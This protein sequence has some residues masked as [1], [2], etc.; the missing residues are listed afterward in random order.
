MHLPALNV[1]DLLIS[2]WR[3]TLKCHN[4]DDTSMWDW[5]VLQGDIWQDHGKAVADARPYLPDS[6]GCAPR[7]PAE[8]I[9]SSYKAWEYI[10]YLYCLRPGVFYRVLPAKY[11][12]HF[13]K[14]VFGIRLAYRRCITSVEVHQG[15]CALLEFEHEFELLY[16][17]RKTCRI[18]FVRPS[19]HTLTHIFPEVKRAGPPSAYTQFSMETAI[20]NLKEEVR[21]PGNPFANLAERCT[22]RGQINGLKAL[23]PDLEPP[24]LLPKW[25]MNLNNGYVLLHARDSTKW[26]APPLH[27]QA[28]GRYYR[29]HLVQCQIDLQIRIQRWARLRL[30]NGQIS[31][32]AWKELQRSQDKPTRTNRNVKIRFHGQIRFAEVHYYFMLSLHAQDD[33]KPV[34]L[35]SLYSK[36]D[37]TL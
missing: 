1:P 31:R 12:R 28:I 25:S 7:N 20:G 13:C 15:H 37:P 6:F 24:Q 3:G 22:R 30:P 26:L 16:Y 32:S 10:I 33:P 2:L 29:Q 34:A 17:R 23:I 36:P 8:K 11:W 18:H 9:N 14:L 21:Q 19:L 4:D 35:I 5:A 27:A